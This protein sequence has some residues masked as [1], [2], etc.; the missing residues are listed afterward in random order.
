MDLGIG[1]GDSARRVLG[2]P[3]ITMAHTEEAIGVI[4]DLVAGE[5][6]TY[7]GTELRLP[8]DRRLDAAGLGR[9]LR[10]DGPGDDRPRRRRRHPPARRSRPHPLVRRPG[11]RGRRGRRSRP[12]VDPGPGRG[13][14]STSAPRD[15]GRER[16]RWF[17]ALVS[18]H[19]VDLVNK[20]PREQLPETLTGYIR[21]RT[22][23]R[24]PPPRRGRLVERRRSSA[25]R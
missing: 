3:P 13:A 25:T 22:G 6:S 14:G 4:R 11:P 9:R 20:Y 5:P 15:V 18:N 1:R 23:L 17:P 19:V 2:K 10:P 21:D 24:L 16:T 8:V 12:G 7:E